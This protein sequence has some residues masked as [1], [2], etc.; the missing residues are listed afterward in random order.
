MFMYWP[1]YEVER[2][3]A[4]RLGVP[5][6]QHLHDYAIGILE[7]GPTYDLAYRSAF[8]YDT[9][10]RLPR[11]DAAGPHLRGPDDM[12]VAGLTEADRLAVPGVEVRLTPTTVWWPDPDPALAAQTMAQY[13]TYLA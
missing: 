10:A 3:A 4:R 5:T 2:S 8:T 1:W 7:S 9:A 12:L 13:R 11:A 6:A